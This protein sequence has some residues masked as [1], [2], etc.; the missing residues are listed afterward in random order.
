[1]L[2]KEKIYKKNNET[3]N[4]FSI[5]SL[6]SRYVQDYFIIKAYMHANMAPLDYINLLNNIMSK[7]VKNNFIQDFL[8]KFDEEL[9]P[10][11]D[12]EAYNNIIQLN[13]GVGK[14]EYH[15]IIIDLRKP[16]TDYIIKQ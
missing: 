5:Q 13:W 6:N 10:P 7:F 15:Y 8:I 2:A 16:M 12:K 14:T 4:Y 11:S 3:N 1:M 9:W